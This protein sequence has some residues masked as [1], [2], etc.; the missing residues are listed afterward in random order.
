MKK[1]FFI[2]I[3]LPGSGK[4][5]QGEF[6]AKYCDIP[7]IS[8]GDI[9]RQAIQLRSIYAVQLKR[10]MDTGVLVPDEIVNSIVKECLLRDEYSNGCVLDGYPR[11]L[12]QAL[13]LS[14]NF[15]EDKIYA[16]FFDIDREVAIQRITGRFSC[17]DCKKIY[18]RYF[19]APTNDGV[20][21][22]CGGGNFVFRSDDREEIV[23]ARF[24]EYEEKTMSIIDYYRN[25]DVLFQVDAMQAKEKVTL[26][27]EKIVKNI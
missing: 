20:C 19:A 22:V 9:F 25:Q 11:N 4:G 21:D 1:N 10:Y 16:I 14:E 13:Y 6:V 15:P 26:E 5:T 8:T 17:A 18:N 3:G 12:S 23:V 2:L 27:L 24:R 7:H